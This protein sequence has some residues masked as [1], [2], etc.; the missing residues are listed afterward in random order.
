MSWPSFV[1]WLHVCA[2]TADRNLL[3]HRHR[4]FAAIRTNLTAPPAGRCEAVHTG[5]QFL[6]AIALGALRSGLCW[7]GGLRLRSRSAVMPARRH[8]FGNGASPRTPANAGGPSHRMP[9]WRGAAATRV[10]RLR[11]VDSDGI[12]P[13]EAR[14]EGFL[15]A[16]R[17]RAVEL[18]D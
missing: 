8:E 1:P 18:G 12:S 2:Q 9:S 6:T 15:L 4:E 17:F 16:E 13:T 14:R 10:V 11:C 3:F 7:L 5:R